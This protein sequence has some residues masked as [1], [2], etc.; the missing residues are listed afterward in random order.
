VLVCVSVC[1]KCTEM[2]A[3][4]TQWHEEEREDVLAVRRLQGLL[5]LKHKA[6]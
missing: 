1:V 6:M 2:K 5:V 3:N 4:R